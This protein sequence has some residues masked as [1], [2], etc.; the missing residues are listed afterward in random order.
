MKYSVSTVVNDI[1][2]IATA[3]VRRDAKMRTVFLRCAEA[4]AAK[5]WE[6]KVI[7]ERVPISMDLPNIWTNGYLGFLAVGNN[8]VVIVEETGATL[9]C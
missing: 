2:Y 1:E 4:I 7:P 9:A 6:S 5:L 3:S 8:A